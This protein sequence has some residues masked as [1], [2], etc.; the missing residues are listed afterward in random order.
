MK[1]KEKRVQHTPGPWT[2]A[3]AGPDSGNVIRFEINQCDFM[4]C[5]IFDSALE[6]D[7]NDRIEAQERDEANANLI[8]SAPQLLSAC[9]C[10]MRAFSEDPAP[11]ALSIVAVAAIKEEV[12]MN[13]YT[14]AEQRIWDEIFV[15]LISG[16]ES[17]DNAAINADAAIAVRRKRF[18]PAP[19]QSKVRTLVDRSA[20]GA[21]K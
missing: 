14:E 20:K 12:T 8:A 16:G 10:A 18:A 4:V 2:I 9:I 19:E 1:T 15:S 5:E 7:G 21:L 3:D 13:D 11:S 17:S 6:P